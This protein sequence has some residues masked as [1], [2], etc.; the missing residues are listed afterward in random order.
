MWKG[1][2]NFLRVGYID[3]TTT[4]QDNFYKVAILG[5]DKTDILF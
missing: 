4:Q 1:Q 2:V 3:A 5:Q